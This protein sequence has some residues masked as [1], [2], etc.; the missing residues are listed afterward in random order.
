MSWIIRD[1]VTLLTPDQEAFVRAVITSFSSRVI[2]LR[3]CTASLAPLLATT[4]VIDRLCA[5]LNCSPNPYPSTP[6][7]D[8]SQGGKKHQ[9]AWLPPED[10]RLLAAIHRFGTQS[11]STVASFVGNNRTRAQCAQRWF[12]GLDP[13]ISKDPWT[14]EEDM[15]LMS[16]AVAGAEEGWTWISR[17]MGSRSDVQCRYRYG[18]LKSFTSPDIEA[19]ELHPLICVNPLRKA[20]A[21]FLP[22]KKGRPMKI[23][24]NPLTKAPTVSMDVASEMEEIDSPADDTTQIQIQKQDS[25]DQLFDWT[26]KV[27]DTGLIF[28]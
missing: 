4:N 18:Q 26:S 12:R 6:E 20:L 16:L 10:N 5:I 24:L 3:A 25:L 2:S 23:K 17:Q 14:H 13:R 15:K 22:K 7:L 19:Q 28:W 8:R 1:E 11:W 9:T 21:P 27:D